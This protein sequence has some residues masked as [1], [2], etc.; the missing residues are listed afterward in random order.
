[1]GERLV[2]VSN[3]GYDSILLI[4]N[5]DRVLSR[6]D[7]TPDTVRDYLR[8]GSK[9]GCWEDQRNDEGLTVDDFGGEVVGENGSLNADRRRFWL[10]D[11]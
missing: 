3:E 6:W 7:A 4:D 8:D 5:Q 11:A 2:F 9:P 10:R 1:M